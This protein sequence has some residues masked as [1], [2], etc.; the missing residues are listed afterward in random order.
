MK[1]FL[2]L[3]LGSPQF[4]PHGHCYLWKPEL[5]GLHLVSD[6]LIAIAYYSIPIT[7]L[8]FVQKRQDTPFNGIFLLFSAFIVA[9]GTTHLLEVW[10]LWH[11][12]YWLS[13]AL[14]LITAVI[15]LYTAFRLVS[16]LPKAL[17][18]PGLSATNQKLAAEIA[19]RQKTEVALR[20]SEERFRNTFEQAAVGI[21]H[22]SLSGQFLR[23]N[24]RFCAIAGY[25]S[26]ELQA[27]T[28]QEITHPDDL[29]SDLQRVHDLLNGTIQTYSLEKRY[30]RQDRS[31]VWI[32]LT[33]SLV[34]DLSG[35][36]KYFIAVIEDID[37][38]KWVELALRQSE[39]TLKLFVKYTP[40]GIAMLDSNFCY[41][42]ASQRWVE[43]YK[44]GSVDFITGH[45]HYELFPEIPERWRKIHQRCLAGAIERCEEDLFERM[46][47]SQQWIRW[48]I[49]P[50]YTINQEIGG[51]IVFSED[52]TE[53]KQAEANLKE[54]EERLRLALTASNQGIYDLNLKTGVAIVNPEYATMLGYDPSHFQ[55]TNTQWVERLHP[56]DKETVASIYQA[57]VAGEIP[58]YKV[59]FR[60]RAE[61][62]D[63]KWI[64]S[65]G[66]IVAWDEDGQPLRMLGTHADI[67]DRKQA[68]A[69]RLQTEQLRLE[70]QLLENILEVTLVG[71]WDW[72]IPANQQ[73]FSPTFKRMFGYEDHDLPNMLETWNQLIWAEDLPGV[74][75]RFDQH[76]KSRG[77]I[78]F[79][80][81]V[82]YRHKDGSAVWVISSGRVIEWDQDDQPLRMIGCQIDIT[83]RKRAETQLQASEAELR[84]LFA[85]MTDTVVVRDREGRCLKIAPNSSSLYRE[86]AE[87]LGRTLHEVLPRPEADS[88]LAQIHTCLDQQTTTSAEYCLPIQQKQVHFLASISPITEN[89]AI[90]VA[91]DISDRKQAEAA[92][93]QAYDELS[94]QAAQLDQTNQTLQTTLEELQVAEEEL[95]LQNEYLIS[96]QT[97]VEAERVRYQDLFN[98]AP[99]GYVVTDAN[100]TIQEANQAIAALVGAE[101]SFLV[102]VP[103]KT[104]ISEPYRPAFK[105][106]LGELNQQSQPQKLQTDELS[107]KPRNGDPV[108][109]AVT[110]TTIRNAQNQIVSMRWLIQDITKR[111]Q[112]EKQL[113]LSSER[114]SL[115]NAELARA[116]RLKD[117]FL[118]GMSHELRTPLNAV[119]GLSEALLEEVYGDL[120]S[121]QRDSLQTIEKSGQHLLSLINDILD[122][123]KI[124]SGKMELELSNVSVRSFCESSLAFVKQQ[125]NHKQ[126]K[127]SCQ[128]ANGLTDL[129][130]DERRLRQVLVNLLSNA[131]KFTPDNGSV[132]LRVNVDPLREVVEFSVTDTGIGI[133]T[134]NME[135]LFQPFVQLDSSLSRRYEGTG[136]GLALVR[137][138]MDLHGGS[139][140]LDSQLGTGSCFTIALPWKHPT[141][142]ID[143][144]AHSATPELAQSGIEMALIV[145]D[146]EAAAN[147]M[148]RYLA[149]LGAQAI[150]HPQGEGALEAA[151]QIQPD[152]IIL[153][154]LLPDQTGWEV[155]AAL[156]IDPATRRI[157]VVVVSVVDSRSRA[158]QL[159]AADFL[160]KPTTR[161]QLQHVLSCV[162]SAAQ[163]VAQTALV[164]T[165]NQC[166]MPPLILLAEDNEANITT[167][168]LYLQAH[169]L[170]VVVAR[171]GLE[172]IQMAQQYRPTLILMDIQMPEIDGLEATRRIRS[173]TKLSQI[174]IIALTA[175]AMPGDRDR[176]LTAGASEYMTKPVS[177]KQLLKLISVYVPAPKTG[178]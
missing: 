22:L 65:L 30:I 155:L 41:V 7:L 87:M 168:T 24:Q 59:E 57:Y 16:L 33:V 118:A 129:E 56:E 120:T 44:L 20:E 151:I 43:D 163:S 39:A 46:D 71:Y 132:K 62:G 8:H 63:W 112:V 79:Y 125:A 167:I 133:A 160:L 76:V 86:S 178:E 91:R 72:H 150:V 98:F 156:K 31:L 139:V 154:I 26:S 75:E 4:I 99:D 11:P 101:Q 130:A 109:V 162:L 36:P 170:Q 18:L 145:E 89:A 3:L 73:Y 49:R 66:K 81:E 169:G 54:S 95:H 115:A 159:G 19:E 27:L 68:E 100:G 70:L 14:K 158:L 34:R 135:R 2:Q 149:N 90:I 5:V 152:V 171:N 122:L 102:N 23:L 147:Q 40:A 131:V 141:N 117:E 69:E 25:P 123:S 144:A 173:D 96:A 84:A 9:C 50:W 128:I 143:L 177:L 80:N 137:R 1:E 93:Q 12:V 175:L 53:R 121:E 107:L 157:P 140:A 138:I 29:E 126:I 161:Q 142:S 48:E 124:E 6:I 166:P 153:D 47:G 172:A 64:L 146:S 165:A 55:E 136:L 114:I 94:Q 88:I 45:S 119:L 103:L 37:H 21:A 58:E 92:L 17:A 38:R 176:C 42:F 127:L 74:M 108:P 106:L 51:I 164:L 32:N 148:V 15:S 61:N 13:G 82:R 52:I 28:F 174:P 97:L 83:E 110:V 85:A 104:Y 113:R 105:D 78:P 77:Q 60:Q 35:E 116:A 10:T 111:K 134:E 67:S